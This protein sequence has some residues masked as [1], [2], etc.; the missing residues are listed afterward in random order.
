MIRSRW[1]PRYSPNHGIGV[2]LKGELTDPFTYRAIIGSL[3]YLTVSRP[4]IMYATCLCARYQSKPKQSHLTAVKRILRYLK[5]CPS[6]GLWYPNNDDF[7]FIAF[8][9]ADWGG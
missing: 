3:M 2:D 6:K 5:G 1:I 8:S 9:D 4:D 7:D